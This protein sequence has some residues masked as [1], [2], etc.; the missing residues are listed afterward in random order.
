MK[1]MVSIVTLNSS[2]AD[3]LIGMQYMQSIELGFAFI[4][5]FINATVHILTCYLTQA[6]KTIHINVTTIVEC[7]VQSI[8]NIFNT[9]VQTIPVLYVNIKLVLSEQWC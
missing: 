4:T 9:T 7:P 2:V 5:Y 6:L 8:N 1:D 3:C